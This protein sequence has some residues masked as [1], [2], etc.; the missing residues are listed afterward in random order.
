MKNKRH[1]KILEIIQ[2]TNTVTQSDLTQKLRDCGMDVTQATVSRDIKEL[3]LV[4]VSNGKDGYKYQ[5]PSAAPTASPKHLT[6]FSQSVIKVDC[7]LHTVVVKT[8]AGMA[9]AAAAAIDSTVGTQILGS[10]AGDDTILIVTD[11]PESAA[12]LKELLIAMQSGKDV[13]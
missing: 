5:Q 3:G 7:A 10:I 12:A 4:K 9:Q 6:I 2:S 8:L 11:S 1:A 13:F